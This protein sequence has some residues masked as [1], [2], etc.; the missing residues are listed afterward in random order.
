MKIFFT[1][2]ASEQADECDRW[3]RE[4]R[5][6]TAGL[7]AQELAASQQLLLLVPRVGPVYTRIDGLPVRRVLL[8]KTKAHVY[9]VLEGPDGP[10]TVLSVWGAPKRG[11]P[12]L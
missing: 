8:R 1:P 2:E 9:Y 5:P 12:E 11:G 10:I 4:H 6:A 3:W 7:F